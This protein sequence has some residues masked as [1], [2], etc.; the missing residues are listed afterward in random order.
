MG[1]SLGATDSCKHGCDDEDNRCPQ[2][3]HDPLLASRVK[4]ACSSGNTVRET[5]TACESGFEAGLKVRGCFQRA[6]FE[7][8]TQRKLALDA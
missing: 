1:Y 2:S 8:C 6:A 7:L 5:R 3:V 4:I